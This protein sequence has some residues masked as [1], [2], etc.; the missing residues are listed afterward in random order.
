M[1]NTILSATDLVE[2]P[3]APVTAALEIAR[4]NKGQLYILHVLE[5]CP[6]G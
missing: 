6:G 4:Q 2:T 1:F 3:D 5:F